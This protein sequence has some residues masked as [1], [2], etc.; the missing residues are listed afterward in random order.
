MF[1]QISIFKKNYKDILILVALLE[2]LNLVFKF[3]LQYNIKRGKKQKLENI[4]RKTL[5]FLSKKQKEIKKTIITII[6]LV[7]SNLSVYFYLQSLHRRRKIFY[8]TK[9]ITKNRRFLY[10]KHWIYS[11]FTKKQKRRHSFT[12]SIQLCNIALNKNNMLK[13]ISSYNKLLLKH[14]YYKKNIK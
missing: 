1:K 6:L 10:I 7:I 11:I 14:L 5:I 2:S 4:Y 12:L 3:L 8:K 9:F 13:E